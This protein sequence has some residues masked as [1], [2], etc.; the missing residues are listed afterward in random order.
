MSSVGK[1][2]GEIRR[3]LK[4]KDLFLAGARLLNFM[5]II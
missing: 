3:F 1:G 4:E 5:E 2:F